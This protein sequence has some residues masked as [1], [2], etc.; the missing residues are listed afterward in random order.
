MT[1]RPEG[2]PLQVLSF[3]FVGALNTA[4]AYALFAAFIYAGWHYTVATLVAGVLSVLTGYKAQRRYVFSFRGDSRLLRF[5][6][7][8]VAIYALSIGIQGALS[9]LGGISH[10]VSGAVATVVCAA[11]S[12]FVNRYYVF[13]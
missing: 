12:F 8:F 3:A 13:R 11:V 5:S 4:L 10:Y 1:S 2:F 6:L 9:D 7:V